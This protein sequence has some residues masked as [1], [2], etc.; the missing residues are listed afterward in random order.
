MAN[1]KASRGTQRGGND[2][3][4]KM[5]EFEGHDTQL[6]AKRFRKGHFQAVGSSVPTQSTVYSPNQKTGKAFGDQSEDR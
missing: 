3:Q 4:A 6:D 2:A 5:G 1:N